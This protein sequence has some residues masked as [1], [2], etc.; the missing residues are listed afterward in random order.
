MVATAHV[1]HIVLPRVHAATK[2]ARKTHKKL[3][4]TGSSASICS[5]PKARQFRN[6]SATCSDSGSSYSLSSLGEER[7]FDAFSVRSAGSAGS[8]GSASGSAD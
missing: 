8:A 6:P 4:R 2:L 1:R 7:S 3:S 5:S